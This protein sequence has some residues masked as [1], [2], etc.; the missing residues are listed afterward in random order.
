MRPSCLTHLIF[1]D[2]I[3]LI[4]FGPNHEALK[5]AVFSILLLPP[6]LLGPDILSSAPYSQRFSFCVSSPIK[7]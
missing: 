5:F 1:F 2:F 7:Y 3:F 6:S 4:I